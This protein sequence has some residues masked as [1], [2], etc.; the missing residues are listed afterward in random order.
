MKV[1][2][3]VVA[4]MLAAVDGVPKYVLSGDD[5]KKLPH[6][7]RGHHGGKTKNGRYYQKQVA[8]RRKKA[9]R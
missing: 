5:E 8:K 3:A 4:A 6:W 2:M 9:G 1:S 7:L